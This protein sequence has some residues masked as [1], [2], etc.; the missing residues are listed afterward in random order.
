M[1]QSHPLSPPKQQLISIYDRRS[2]QYDRSPFHAHLAQILIDYAQIEAGQQ[3]LDMATGTGLVALIAAERVGPQGQVVGVDMSGGMLEQARRKASE[4]N[5]PNLELILGDAETVEFAAD[6][7]DVILCSAAIVWLKDIP[8]TLR[9]WSHFLKPAGLMAF[10]GFSESSFV[11]EVL[12]RRVARKHGIPLR[13]PHLPTG[14]AERCAALLHSAGFTA[15]EVKTDQ[16]GYF[17]SESEGQE[18]LQ[19]KLKGIFPSGSD[20]NPLLQQF[21]QQMEQFRADFTTEFA[22]LTTAQGV[23]NELTAYTALGCKPHSEG[24][25]QKILG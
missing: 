25:P 10:N 3:V 5:L 12:L 13:N 4:A 1:N 11:E 9:R 20:Q 7:F 14:T 22:A 21:H 2:G 23:W 24:E 19:E 16:L 8:A 17:L 6:R 18:M 15:I